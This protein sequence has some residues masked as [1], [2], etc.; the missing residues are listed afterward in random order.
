[1]EGEERRAFEE[2]PQ[3]PEK[4]AAERTAKTKAKP[5]GRKPLPIHLEAEEDELHPDA[6][7]ACGGAAL[8]VADEL[9]EEKL[10]VVKEH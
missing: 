3:A 6:C 1:M 7:S 4:P 2:R 10:H 5:T 8:D 9:L